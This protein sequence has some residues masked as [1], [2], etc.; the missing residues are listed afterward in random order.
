MRPKPWLFMV[1]ACLLTAGCEGGFPRVVVKLGEGDAT[2]ADSL[3]PFVIASDDTEATQAGAALLRAGGTAG[4]AAA[5][6][7]LTLAVTLP[8]SASLHARGVCLVHDAARGETNALDFTSLE[9]L[10]LARAALT[11]HGTLGALPWARTVAPAANLAR[12]G[13]PLSRTVAERLSQADVLLA[14]PETLMLFMSA[15]RQLLGAGAVL[16]MPSL[17]AALDRLRL[18]PRGAVASVLTWSKAGSDGNERVFGTAGT[19]VAAG[20]TA[21]VV[22]DPKGNAVAC[23]LGLGR[24]FGRGVLVDGALAP[25]ATAPL[26][27]SLAVDSRGRILRAAAGAAMPQAPETAFVCRLDNGAP[28]CEARAPGGYGLTGEAGEP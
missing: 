23:A 9:S 20:S 6:I 19:G 7:A 15:R 26:K 2:A 16:R 12:F 11:L 21:F 17:A 3:R 25:A 5:A 22:G 8:S 18:Q 28:Q 10:G 1:L 14:N 13:H 27:T 24:P 4:D